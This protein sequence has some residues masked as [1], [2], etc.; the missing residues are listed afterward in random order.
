MVNTDAHLCEVITSEGFK[1]F[2]ED[3][4][5]MDLDEFC[6]HAKYYTCGVHARHAV[7]E[8]QGRRANPPTTKAKAP[9]PTNR[10]VDLAN[11]DKSSPSEDRELTASLSD[12][13]PT[14]NIPS[15]P[16][17]EKQTKTTLTQWLRDSVY[18]GLSR[19]D[20]HRKSL[21]WG[22]L[23]KTLL[24]GH[25]IFDNYPEGV[26]MPGSSNRGIDLLN[27]TEWKKM[28]AQINDTEYPC[29]IRPAT[30][31]EVKLI[32]AKKI[33]VVMG[34][35]PARHSMQARGRAL[36]V[37]GKEDS[38]LGYEQSTAG[39]AHRYHRNPEETLRT[40][41]QTKQRL[42]DSVENHLARRG[43]SKLSTADAPDGR[44][45]RSPHPASATEAMDVDASDAAADYP[46]EKRR[47]SPSDHLHRPV[48]KTRTENLP[49]SEDKD[50]TRLPGLPLTPQ[51]VQ[52][53]SNSKPKPRPVGTGRVRGV[54]TS[55]SNADRHAVPSLSSRTDTEAVG[56][57]VGKGSP[58]VVNI[59]LKPIVH[60]P[61]R[62]ARQEGQE[63]GRHSPPLAVASAAAA[64]E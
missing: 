15:V 35:P 44:R 12:Q 43:T 42:E 31:E 59:T 58:S 56:K 41:H 4:L 27:N 36:D 5:K 23:A 54:H 14:A 39:P 3:H 10:A 37:Q 55:E 53:T 46:P 21:P 49:L 24:D 22:K 2:M 50:A 11:G 1:G 61:K 9:A 28:W 17:P 40:L 63:Q 29:R 18:V 19:K 34:V 62:E 13:A 60:P 32:Q 7:E 16:I 25:L 52:T 57:A 38:S 20:A 45:A 6:G 33:G 30:E 26:P 64:T 51:R 48:K 47:R 8:W